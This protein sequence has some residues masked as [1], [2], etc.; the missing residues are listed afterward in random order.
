MSSTLSVSGSE[1]VTVWD[2]AHHG[3]DEDLLCCPRIA[4][5]GVSVPVPWPAHKVYL[6]RESRALDRIERALRR[7]PG[8]MAELEVRTGLSSGSVWTVIHRLKYLGVAVPVGSKQVRALGRH[9]TIY[10][11]VTGDVT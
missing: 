11:L 10:G 1:Y 6:A 8:T 9:A 7:E 4:Q 2:G 5:K 3:A